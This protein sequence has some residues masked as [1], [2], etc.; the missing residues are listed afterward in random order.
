MLLLMFLECNIWTNLTSVNL[1][2][3]QSPHNDLSYDKV[4]MQNIQLYDMSTQQ[5]HSDI[6]YGL[7][8]THSILLMDTFYLI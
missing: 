7:W 3:S 5:F 1:S 8:Y 4:V 6:M 2:K